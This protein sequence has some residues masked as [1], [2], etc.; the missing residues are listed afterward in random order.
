MDTLSAFYMICFLVGFGLSAIS[1]LFGFFDLSLHLPHAPHVDLGGHDFGGQVGGH[2]GDIGDLGHVGGHGGHI[3]LGDAG[4]AGDGAPGA[5]LGHAG[6]L[7]HGAD[8]SISPFNFGTMMSFVTWFG[9]IGYIL[10]V[11]SGLVGVL[12][13]VIAL[14]GGLVGASIVFF[15]LTK[16]LLPGQ[17]VLDPDDFYMPG[18]IA[19]VTSSIREGGAGEI[20]YS[21]AGTR[22]TSGARSES[23]RAIKRGE[24]V[25]ITGYTGGMAV[26]QPWAEFVKDREEKGEE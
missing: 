4:H 21:L 25:V 17:R 12:V 24:E 26:V 7:A 23:G 14:G 6:E 10:R 1:F 16:L 5:H 9:G 13:A 18:T 2:V 11:Y 8:T 15:F 22:R 19:R 20:V 3:D